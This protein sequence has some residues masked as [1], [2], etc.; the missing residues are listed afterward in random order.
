M[1]RRGWAGGLPRPEQ[2]PVLAARHCWVRDPAG[3]PGRW[4][5]LL[6]EW[7]RGSEGWQGRVVYA[8]STGDRVHLVEE[9]LPAASLL[10]V[11]R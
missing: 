5:G 6:A 1:H 9:W 2:A 8:V 3:H 11:H 10:P 7:R 4:P